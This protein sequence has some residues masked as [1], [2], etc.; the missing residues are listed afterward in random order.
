ML[1]TALLSCVFAVTLLG[2]GGTVQLQ[3]QAHPFV[4]T[5]FSAETSLG[6]DLSILVQDAAT[7]APVLDADVSLDSE[8][9]QIP[10]LLGRGQNKL[11]Y[12]ATVNLPS[13]ADRPFRVRVDR[14]ATHVSAQGILHFPPKTPE[15]TRM[16]Y[17]A[18]VPIGILLF[19]LRGYL[20]SRK[21]PRRA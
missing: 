5:V 14:A 6:T 18:I 11:L 1:R 21:V 7:L 8:G 20:V 19:V 4:I 15:T 3:A 16:T 9:H 2:D 10:A 12:S 17:I 13:S